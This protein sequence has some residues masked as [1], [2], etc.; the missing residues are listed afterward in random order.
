MGELPLSDESL[1]ARCRAGD[2]RAWGPLVKRHAP[3]V[4]RLAHRSVRRTDEA[5]DLVQEIF[6][7]VSRSLAHYDKASPFRPWLLQVAR[8]HLIDHH[9]SHRREKEATVALE[10]VVEPGRPAPQHADMVRAER[11]TLLR[12]AL[13]ELPDVL[14]EA[15]VLRDIDGLD[16]EEI[17]AALVVPLGT[18]KSRINRG[19]LQLA[20]LLTG[21]EAD[22]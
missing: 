1:V 4:F 12:R 8:H 19:R 5:E 14:R 17:A 15:V 20:A 16:Y 22:A 6:W 9:R 21:Q 13:E 7:K 18:V 2:E 11:A 10:N 3:L